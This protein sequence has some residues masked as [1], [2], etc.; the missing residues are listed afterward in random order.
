MAI[1]I[2]LTNSQYGVP[3]TGA[4]FRVVAAAVTRTRNLDMRHSVM[5]DVAGYAT[6]P[7]DEDTRD[8]DFRR[9]H[10]PLSEIEACEG[11]TFLAKCYAWAMTQPDMQGSVGV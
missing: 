8:I 1:Q 2:D 4:Y 10:C 6:A 5:I 11:D 9:Y 7:Q 3:F